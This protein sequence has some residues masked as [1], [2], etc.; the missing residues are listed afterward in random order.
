[1]RSLASDELSLNSAVFS[2]TTGPILLLHGGAWD[3]PD[4]ELGA[5]RHGLEEAL[6]CGIEL[7]SQERSSEDVVVEVIATMEDSGEFD[8]GRGSVLREDQ[9]AVLDAGIMRGSDLA[10]GSVGAVRR[11]KNPIRASRVILEAGK[12]IVR[13]AVG[14]DAEELAFRMGCEM[15]DPEYHICK[16]ELERYQALKKISSYHTS[17]NFKDDSAPRGTV[18]C[19]VREPDGFVVAGTSTGGTPLS[20]PGRVGD[21]PLPGSGFY[22]NRIAGSS[23]TGWGEAIATVNLCSRVVDRMGDDQATLGSVLCRRLQEMFST[24]RSPSG[25]GATGGVITVTQAGEFGWCYTTPRMAR[26]LWSHS[27][28]TRV[29]V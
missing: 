5:Y 2:E 13:F 20:P 8:A 19:V 12:G 25:R 28:G 26:A 18:G 10:F 29:Y 17:E 27:N 14:A 23:A 7:L 21:T 15:V 11:I 6:A 9:T 16:R 1:M 24:V 3:I 4:G 22:A